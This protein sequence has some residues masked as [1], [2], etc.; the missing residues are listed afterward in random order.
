MKIYIAGKITGLPKT[1][2]AKK[3]A[4]AETLIKRTGHRPI[5]PMAIDAWGLEHK[6]YMS[7]ARN[8]LCDEN[9]DA[10][11]MLANWQDSPGA[12]E[13]HRIAESL[14]M[15]IYYEDPKTKKGEQK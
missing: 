10:I 9:T 5:N 8:V 3:F 12:Q 1:I 15:P 6:R 14:K 13:E 7:I 4:E 2:A 11:Y